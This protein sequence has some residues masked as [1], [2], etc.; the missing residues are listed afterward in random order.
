MQFRVSELSSRRLLS[1]FAPPLVSFAN[2]STLEFDTI[3]KKGAPTSAEPA[4]DDFSQ[5]EIVDIGTGQTSAFDAE[6]DHLLQSY[7][8]ENE[9]EKRVRRKADLYLLPMLWIM[10]VACYIDRSNIVSNTPFAVK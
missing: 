9:V 7:V 1:G 10:C 5:G 3:D 6:L 8:P 4:P 2:M